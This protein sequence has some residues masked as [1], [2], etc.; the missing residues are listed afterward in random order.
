MIRWYF[1]IL[2]FAASAF[3]GQGP[4]KPLLAQLVM[5]AVDD[6]F[7]SEANVASTSLAAL[8]DYVKMK[9]Q[10]MENVPPAKPIK[11]VPFTTF[12]LRG[13]EISYAS[14]PQEA[15]QTFLG[16]PTIFFGKQLAGKSNE[17]VDAYIRRYFSIGLHRGR[18]HYDVFYHQASDYGAR[19]SGFS[20]GSENFRT[21]RGFTYGNGVVFVID[22]EGQQVLNAPVVTQSLTHEE[23]I[24]TMGGRSPDRIQAAIVYERGEV[25][26]FYLNPNYRPQVPASF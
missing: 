12:K 5:S 25:K 13:T 17:E 6:Y 10:P 24:L 7:S 21:A 20:N 22:T 14:L 4:C 19:D 1:L 16:D 18:G 8:E 11:D 26:S 9:A 23:E 3:A 15:K 2:S